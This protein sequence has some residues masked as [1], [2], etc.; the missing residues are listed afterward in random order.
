MPSSLLAADHGAADSGVV[1][2][3]S[4]ENAEYAKTAWLGNTFS[5]ARRRFELE[6]DVWHKHVTRT[7]NGEGNAALRTAR[8]NDLYERMGRGE[9]EADVEYPQRLIEALNM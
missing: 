6:R 5:N 3:D 7:E 8:I 2:A 9:I 4:L 1:D